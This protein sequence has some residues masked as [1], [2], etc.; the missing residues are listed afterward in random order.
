MGMEGREEKK[1]EGGENFFEFFEFFEF[2][3]FFFF[4]CLRL[5]LQGEDTQAR[6]A[7]ATMA[8]EEAREEVENDTPTR[9][10]SHYLK[11][12]KR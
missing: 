3:N 7:A 8:W 12:K 6:P 9:T 2:L 4:L 1:R 5:S 11:T 10:N